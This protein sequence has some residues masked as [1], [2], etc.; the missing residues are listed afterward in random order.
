MI[1]FCRTADLLSWFPDLGYME[2]EIRLMKT[3]G[4]PELVV[5]DNL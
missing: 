3:W 2:G 4:G 5:L 1:S